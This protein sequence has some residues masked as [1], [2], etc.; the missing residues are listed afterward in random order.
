MI[1]NFRTILAKFIVRRLSRPRPLVVATWLWLAADT[2]DIEE[3]RR[4]LWAVLE[5][6]PEN[7]RALLGLLALVLEE[8]DD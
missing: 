8:A 3:K 1:D 2:D 5:L 7:T 6:D 4:C